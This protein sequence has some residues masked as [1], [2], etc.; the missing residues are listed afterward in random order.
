MIKRQ[1][2]RGSRLAWSPSFRECLRQKMSCQHFLH[3]PLLP[4]QS[5]C[6]HLNHTHPLHPSVCLPFFFS[7]SVL[8]VS[9]FTLFIHP[10]IFCHNLFCAQCLERA[11]ADPSYH[12]V[13]VGYTLD[14]S[15]LITERTEHVYI[16]K[17]IPIL[18]KL[19]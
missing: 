6:S 15:Q 14:K 8:V 9:S 5:L 1:R 13:K 17:N 18:T 12:K 10:S 7:V 11:G 2:E 4:D 3:L 19:R 16:H